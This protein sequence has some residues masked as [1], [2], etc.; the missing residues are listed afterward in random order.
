MFGNLVSSMKVK[1]MGK[2]DFSLDLNTRNSL[3]VILNYIE[4]NSKVLEFGCANGR[5]TK[6][7]KDKLNCE[8]DIVEIDYEAGMEAAKYANKKCLGTTE[9]NIE[10]YHWYDM[11]SNSKYD[12][13]IFADV[14]EHLYYPARVLRKCSNLLKD[15]G[16]ILTSIPNIAHNSIIIGLINDK[17]TYTNVGLLDNTHIRFFTEKSFISMVNNIGFIVASEEVLVAKVGEIEVST[18]YSMVNKAVQRTL[19]NRKKGDVYQYIFELQKK[20]FVSDKNK[21]MDIKQKLPYIC[22]CFIQED[23]DEFYSES[24]KII[25]RMFCK[26]GDVKKIEFDLKE[27]SCIKNIRL[28]PLNTNCI[29]EI[30]KIALIKKDVEKQVYNFLTNGKRKGLLYIFGEDPQILINNINI[31]IEKIILEYKIWN[32]DYDISEEFLPYYN[33][34]Y[35]DGDKILKKIL[36]NKC[37]LLKKLIINKMEKYKSIIY[38]K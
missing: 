37:K 19:K 38:K 34:N 6:Y 18:D 14:L 21:I 31:K 8:V 16:K 5:M 17:F 22:E 3:S 35:Y 20:S 29:L 36:N 26:E 9:G 1:I 28:D 15:E 27:F 2:Y 12:Y 24:K 33:E 4:K 23:D 13:I 10:N 25:H 11:L 32:F 30:N 7:M